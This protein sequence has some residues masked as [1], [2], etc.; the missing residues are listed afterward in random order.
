MPKAPAFRSSD[1]S[2]ELMGTDMS[3]DEVSWSLARKHLVVSRHKAPLQCLNVLRFHLGF[4]LQYEH[5][6]MLSKF[7]RIFFGSSQPAIGGM[8]ILF[9]TPTF[10][11][12][13]PQQ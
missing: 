1:S 5:S 13:L 2:R 10:K 9:N 12:G 8:L 3:L 7:G 6:T 11:I 4:K